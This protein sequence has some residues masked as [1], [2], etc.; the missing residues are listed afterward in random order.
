MNKQEYI[1]LD[2]HAIHHIPSCVIAVL[3]LSGLLR[4]A[5]RKG[6]PE[7]NAETELFPNH[8]S[9]LAYTKQISQIN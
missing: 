1:I 9:R 5:L 7:R 8:L 3:L 2:Q 6:G 4:H